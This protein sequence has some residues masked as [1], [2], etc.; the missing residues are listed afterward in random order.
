M[1]KICQKKAVY[2]F[3]QSVVSSAEGSCCVTESVKSQGVNSVDGIYVD[4]TKSQ[5]ATLEVAG[6][7]AINDEN[8]SNITNNLDNIYTSPKVSEPC[9]ESV[10]SR[11]RKLRPLCLSLKTVFRVD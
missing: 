1:A 6:I 7:K 5:S 9:D 10:V 8:A 3:S 4:S 2:P 11:F